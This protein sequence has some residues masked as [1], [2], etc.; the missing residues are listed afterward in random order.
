MHIPSQS[1]IIK[2]RSTIS[3]G[4]IFSSQRKSP[5]YLTHPVIRKG[6]LGAVHIIKTYMLSKRIVG[7]KFT[8]L[9]EHLAQIRSFLAKEII[10]AFIYQERR[11]T[12]K[13][14]PENANIETTPFVFTS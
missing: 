12:P 14:K 10:K 2:E 6:L 5:P 11:T 13:M 9:H 1:D 4:S 8:S 3:L 7:R